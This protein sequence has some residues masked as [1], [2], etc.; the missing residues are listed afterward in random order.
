MC[1]KFTSSKYICSVLHTLPERLFNNVDIVARIREENTLY[2][3]IPDS[4]DSD[5]SV[6]AYI[7]YII[8]ITRKW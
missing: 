6:A 8:I 1:N 3:S 5:T 2:N 4:S 7:I